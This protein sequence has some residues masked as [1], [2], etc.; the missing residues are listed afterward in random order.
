MTTLLNVEHLKNTEL[1]I[2]LA[3]VCV[4]VYVASKKGPVLLSTEYL[5]LH[6]LCCK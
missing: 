5:Q 1:V 4:C 3:C 6:C 2:I